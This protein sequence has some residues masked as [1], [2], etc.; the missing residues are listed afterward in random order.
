MSAGNR[1]CSE[2]NLRDSWARA[3]EALRERTTQVEAVVR[4]AYD[5]HLAPDSSEGLALVAVG[6]FGRREMFPHSDVDLLLVTAKPAVPERLRDSIRDFLQSLW[7]SGLRVSHSVRTVEDCA[8]LHEENVELSVSLLDE[9]FLSGDRGLHAALGIALARLFYGQRQTLARH[10]CR[11]ARARHAK[12]GGSIYQLEPNIKEGQGG[13]RDYQLAGWLNRLRNAQPDRTPRAEPLPELDAARDFLFALRGFLHRRAGRDANSLSFDL[14]EELADCFEADPADWMRRYYRH[15]REIAHAALRTIEAVDEQASSLLLQF[16]DWRSRVS[17]AEFYVSRERVYFRAPNRL[18]LDPALVLRLFVFVAHH[19]LRLAL[20]TERRIDERAARLRAW[21]QESPGTLWPALE[22][23]LGEPHCALALRAMHQAG[24][25]VMLLPE[26]AAVECL[27]IRDFYHRYTVDEHTLHAIETLTALR[28]SAEPALRRLA[29]LYSEVDDPGLLAF[30]LIFHDL[31]KAART[32]RHV[33]ESVRLAEASMLRIGVPEEQ[34]NAVRMLI[35]G[36]LD[37][38][39]VMSARDL[40][41]P[42]TACFLAERA[43]TV[44]ILKKLTLLTYADVSAVKP[45]AMTPWRLEQLWRV[46]LIAHRALTREL[47]AGRM[48]TPGAADLAEAKEFVDGFPVRYL[49]THSPARIEA[50]MELERRSRERGVA[51][52]IRRENGFHRLTLVARDRP[53][54]LASIA[55]ALA[56]FGMNIRKAEGF[57]NRHGIVLNTF[58]FEDPHRTLE[59]NPTETDRLRLTVERVTLGRLDVRELLRS[60]AVPRPPSRRAHIVPTVTFDSEASGSATLVEVVAEDRP[61]LLYALASA[62]AEAGDDISVVLIDT[63]AHK[64]I[65]VFYVTR[66]GRKLAA[67]EEAP[68]RDVLLKACQRPEWTKNGSK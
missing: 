54:L 25:L 46:Y 9:R 57:A 1:P 47:G 16:R 21:F 22:E 33:P 48:G 15:A 5:R 50:D 44:E 26:W 41:D 13:L 63:E 10:L 59:L 49:R 29:D 38:S 40:D 24:V 11:L 52:D 37:L 17:N 4:A 12:H 60:R 39:S 2:P 6:G 20:E 53:L 27:V 14:Q 18:E 61:G 3:G 58:V 66:G 42:S 45:G 30:A 34:R 43:G 55:G 32:G 8:E 36:H 51:V 19:G 64:A 67:D 31:G 68:L 56:G 7:D 62:I 28:G 65:D 35:E 23:L